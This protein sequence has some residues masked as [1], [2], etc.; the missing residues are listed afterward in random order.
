MGILGLIATILAGGVCANARPPIWFKDGTKLNYPRY[1][2]TCS[3]SG[4][5][6]DQARKQAIN[7]C[8]S[9]AM[10]Q[11][12][13]NTRYKSVIIET[14]RD[15]ALHS[16]SVIEATV[17]HLQC[18]SRR[19]EVEE[20]ESSFTAYVLCDFDLSKTKLTE[21][22]PEKSKEDS[23]GLSQFAVKPVDYTE[24]TRIPANSKSISIS[25]APQCQDILIRGRQSRIVRCSENPISI[26]FSETDT[27]FVIRKSGFRSKT[28]RVGDIIHSKDE[29][30]VFPLD[31]I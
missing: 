6:L 26:I 23:S 13:S 14:E 8:K 1:S 24:P 4:P 10:D 31:P 17:G 5:S 12:P 29:S 19:E 22:P 3:A 7:N 30:Y 15:V 21:S 2:V 28:V 25:T 27:E 20:A 16:E 9:S 11:L 18:V